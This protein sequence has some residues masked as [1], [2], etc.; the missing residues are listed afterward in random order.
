MLRSRQPRRAATL[1]P[2]LS[3]DDTTLFATILRPDVPL[4]P[5]ADSG[6]GWSLAGVVDRI[7]AGATGDLL[8]ITCH[9]T[10]LHD[11]QLA[12]ALDAVSGE[13]NVKTFADNAQEM[14]FRISL[15]GFGSALDRTAALSK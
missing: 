14:P 9:L 7:R 2:Y 13:M 6:N 4:Q 5:F 15:K 12:R 11:A 8:A 10:A 1:E 3:Q